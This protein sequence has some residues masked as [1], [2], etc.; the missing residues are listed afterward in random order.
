[1][2]HLAARSR[3]LSANDWVLFLTPCHA[4][5]WRSHTHARTPMRFLDCSPPGWAPAV[6]C[7][8]PEGFAPVG[9]LQDS[10]DSG[11]SSRG[12]GEG[13]SGSRKPLQPLPA[14]QWECHLRFN[15]S[16]AGDAAFRS[17]RQ[18][19]E[20]APA[21]FLQ[22]HFPGDANGGAVGGADV[23]AG[24]SGS[25][26]SGGSNPRGSL[27]KQLVLF[28]NMLDRIAAWARPRGYVQTQ[29]FAHAHFGVDEEREAAV[30]LLERH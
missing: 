25:L 18:R 27:P 1:M 28:D 21:A 3:R 4:T 15:G 30:L 10:S 9:R 8:N 6:A 7:L 17:E 22:Q 24:S 13:G 26:I 12:S 23:S 20:A 14:E 5:P 11:R 16:A 2:A 19:F 29:R